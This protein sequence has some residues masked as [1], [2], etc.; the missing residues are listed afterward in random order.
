MASLLISIG[1]LVVSTVALVWQFISWLRTGPV[2]QVKTHLAIP[3]IGGEMSPED[4]LAVNATNRGRSPA[5]ITGWGLL[6][7]GGA[8][9]AATSAPLPGVEPLPFR[10]DPF[11]ETSWY[12]S[13]AEIDH[14]CQARGCSRSDIRP[15]VIVSGQGRKT[16]KRLR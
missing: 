13:D 16:G 3:V 12:I 6:L 11:A 4:F 2:I 9:T 7:P 14:I 5:T 10:I 1:A 8:T 15:F